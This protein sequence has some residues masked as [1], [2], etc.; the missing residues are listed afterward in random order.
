VRRLLFVLVAASALAT[1]LWVLT[2]SPTDPGTYAVEKRDLVSMDACTGDEKKSQDQVDCVVDIAM[3]I[4]TRQGVELKRW[5]QAL[6]T[7]EEFVI[8]HEFQYGHDLTHDFFF[9]SKLDY[10]LIQRLNF[11]RRDIGFV[12]SWQEWFLGQKENYGK[13]QEVYEKICRSEQNLELAEDCSHGLGHVAYRQDLG[14]FADRIRFCDSLTGFA[15]DPEAEV[16]QCYAGLLMSHGP[17]GEDPTLTSN[18]RPSGPLP[19]PTRDE[20]AQLCKNATPKAAERCWPWVVWF[21]YDEPGL[22]EKYFNVCDA[23]GAGRWC[24]EGIARYLFFYLYSTSDDLY[25]DTMNTCLDF[26][27]GDQTKLGCA[28]EVVRIDIEDWM[29]KGNRTYREFDCSV[30]REHNGIC[31]QAVEMVF[32]TPCE[33]AQDVEWMDV[34]IRNRKAKHVGV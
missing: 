15:H 5:Q 7:M 32:S 8:A 11:D 1:V 29:R 6:D 33:V 23:S 2:T 16:G 30:I 12:H 24:G 9:A 17:H 3:G 4:G 20:A 18:E 14:T 10:S 22:L 26:P 13:V 21:Y 31:A 27:G 25:V 28:I 34:C 19:R